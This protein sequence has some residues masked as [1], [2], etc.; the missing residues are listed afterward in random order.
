[1]KQ[2]HFPTPILLSL[3]CLFFIANAPHSVQGRDKESSAASG[4][5]FA[6]T[7][8]EGGHLVITRSPTLGRNV[9]ITLKIDGQLA[10]SLG[11]GRT[12]DRYLAPGRHVLTASA[13][14]TSGAWH[15]TLDVR[16]GHTY[17]YSA[18]YSVDKLVL[19]PRTR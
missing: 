15:A 7:A 9:T 8:S 17:S 13:T 4:A 3:I 10:G 6:S 5:I 14:R 19:T 18:A 16:A 11:W 1:M 12:Y 2:S